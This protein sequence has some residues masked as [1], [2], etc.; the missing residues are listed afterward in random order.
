MHNAI[1]LDRDGTLN[2]DEKGYTYKVKDFKLLPGV[3]DGLKKLSDF[4]FFIITNQSGIGKGFYS[5]KD[6]HKYNLRMLIE[7]EKDDVRIEKIYFCPH[8]FSVPC[9]CRKPSPKFVKEAEKKFNLNL[10]KSFVIGDHPSDISL[11]KNAGCHGIY[12]LTGHGNQHLKEAV[13][14]N[15]EHI[16]KNFKQATEYILDLTK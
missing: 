1:F 6:M 16:A 13:K 8:D 2:D 15:P 10:E 4:K 14:I 11:A 9:D 3:I 5:E 12:L 7:F